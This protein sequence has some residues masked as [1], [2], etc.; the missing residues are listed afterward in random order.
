MNNEEI[1]I[2]ERQGC[3]STD[4]SRVEIAEGTDLSRIRN[5]YFCGPVKIGKGSEIINVPGGIS[6]VRIGDYVRIINV[7]RIENSSNASFGVGTDVAVLDETGGR[8]VRIY[9][10]ISAQVAAISARMPEYA[11]ETLFPMIDRHIGEMKSEARD[12]P[13]IGDG[14]Q[15]FDCGPITDVRVWPGVLI[16]GAAMLHNGSV[17]SNQRHST[18]VGQ[19][20]NAENF[21]IEDASVAN[22]VLLRNTYVGQGSVLDKGFT[23]HDSLFFANCSMENGE[24][25]ALLAG[26]YTVSMHKS[27]LLIGC[28]TSFMNAGSGTNMS[29]HMYKLGP[30]HLGVL[31]R[32]VKTSSNSYMMH[33]S[34]VGAFSLVMGEHKTHPDS[35]AFPFSYL[36]GDKDGR[37]II[38]PGAMLRSYGLKR[39][40]DKWPKRDRRIGHGLRLNDRISFDILNP[41]TAGLILEAIDIIDRL[42]P[43][44]SDR[45]GYV[46][47][48][49]LKIKRSSLEKGRGLYV[50]ALSKYVDSLKKKG[51]SEH[52]DAGITDQW[53]DL[54]GQVVT[55]SDFKRALAADSIPEMEKALDEAAASYEASELKW[56]V[57]RLKG[58]NPDHAS[59]F[60][61]LI[62][63]DRTDSLARIERENEMLTLYGKTGIH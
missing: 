17:V 35:S 52:P 37:T 1:E 29:N 53:I 36:F 55:E 32:G 4:W 44:D 25:C 26:P 23:S 42:L 3:F 61:T 15:I 20:V 2:L 21:I 43:Q 12:M 47:Y 58:H 19:G 16:E 48:K 8:P 63:K 18:Y 13:E 40:G 11:A 33:G 49:G 6:N 57:I 14:A 9:P 50:L 5:V 34:R 10:G 27:S 31:E 54:L 60:D 28:Q 39:D 38:V 45:E 22:G 30:V 59:E 56:A 41:H 7:A 62:E 24:A 51:A 46:G